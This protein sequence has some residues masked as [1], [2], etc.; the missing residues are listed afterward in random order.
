MYNDALKKYYNYTDSRYAIITM[1]ID[2]AP[3]D[4]V[5]H[6]CNWLL[7]K[8]VPSTIFFTHESEL[9]NNLQLNKNIEI[10]IHPDF[11]RNMD[12]NRCEKDMLKLYPNSKG[13]RSHKNIDGRIV[14]DALKKNNI[15]YH[16][17]KL[18]W[19]LSHIEV[20]PVYNGLLEAPYFWEDGYHLELGKKLSID[21][22][23]IDTPGLKIFNI[24]PMLFFLNCNDDDVRKKATYSIEDLTTTNINDFKK[25]VN[26]GI[27]ITTLTKSI[28]NYLIDKKYKFLLLNE[29]MSVA[30]KNFQLD[31][32]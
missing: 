21:E 9:A 13:S 26:K 1:D 5:E 10:G 4:I 11:S 14:T 31:F 2:W 22:I 16:S 23:N 32:S 17:N 12:A 15:L 28:I 25:F 8:N 20:L 27:G 30:R 18:T 6:T 7:S 3:D 29:V 19:G 24:H